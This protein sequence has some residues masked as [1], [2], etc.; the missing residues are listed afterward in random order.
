M[1]ASFF[2]FIHSLKLFDKYLLR[3]HCAPCGTMM[4]NTAKSSLSWSLYLSK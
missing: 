3:A 2:P 1:D 4:P